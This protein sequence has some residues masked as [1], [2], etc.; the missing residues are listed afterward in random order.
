MTADTKSPTAV[1]RLLQFLGDLKPMRWVL[2]GS[3]ILLLFLV[4]DAGTGAHYEGWDIVP[5]VLLPVI[6]PLILMLLLLDALMTR[7]FSS[8]A[9]GPARSQ[10]RATMWANLIIAI[11]LLLRWVPY[12]AALHV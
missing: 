8:D 7:V 11:V 9:E 1:D 4:P 6:A 3:A 5:T 2:M 12:Y 10:L